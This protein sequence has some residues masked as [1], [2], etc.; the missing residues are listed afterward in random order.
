[1]LSFNLIESVQ[2]YGVFQDLNQKY[3]GLQDL[4]RFQFEKKETNAPSLQ[5]S[6]KTERQ[7]ILRKVLEK[8]VAAFD[9]NGFKLRKNYPNSI[10]NPIKDQNGTS[11]FLDC[12]TPSKVDVHENK[13]GQNNMLD[14]S[15]DL[16]MLENR[17]VMKAID[18][19]V[20]LARKNGLKTK[21]SS[22]KSKPDEKVRRI[23]VKMTKAVMLRTDA[24]K[25][26]Y[27]N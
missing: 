21:V 13:N 7:P 5:L 10:V 12:S 19:N 11:F 4:K 8:G 23:I 3:G 2:K 25:K 14:L 27:S 24:N 17:G 15:F 22:S 1:M 18:F 26:K 6:L 16:G 20:P 9:V